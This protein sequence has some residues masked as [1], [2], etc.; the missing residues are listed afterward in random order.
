MPTYFNMA[1]NNNNNN[2]N[3]IYSNLRQVYTLQNGKE[4]KREQEEKIYTKSKGE[5]VNKVVKTHSVNRLL[6]I[7]DKLFSSTKSEESR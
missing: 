1:N 4:E 6:M 7:S 2:N 3:N 5:W